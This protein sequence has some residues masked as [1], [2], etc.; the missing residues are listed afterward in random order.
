MFE[1]EKSEN[2]NIN[3]F[4]YIICLPSGILAYYLV[5]GF[6]YVII[7][8]HDFFIGDNWLSE[9]IPFI[10]DYN[11]EIIISILMGFPAIA[12]V[13]M[14]YHIIPNFKKLLGF[15]L[16]IIYTI[17]FIFIF[18]LSYLE[19]VQL[20]YISLISQIIGVLYSCYFVFN[21]KCLIDFN[22]H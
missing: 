6:L 13:Y 1:F 9:Y 2:K 3:I 8:M 16:I 7:Y 12:W 18:Y 22:S 11:P 17:N 20:D 21:K 14:P 5:L 15:I 4:R 10:F 19:M